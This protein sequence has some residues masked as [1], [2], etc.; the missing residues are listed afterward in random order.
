MTSLVKKLKDQVFRKKSSVE[1]WFFDFYRGIET[2]NIVPREQFV[3]QSE[4]L[5]YANCYHGVWCS[6]LK[7]LIEEAASHGLS[8]K[9]FLDVG[10]GKGKACFYAS[11]YDQFTE[12]EGIEFDPKL[13]EISKQNLKKF[14]GHQEKI[15]FTLGDAAEYKMKDTETFI[16]LFNPFDSFV[17]NK[18]LKNNLETIRNKCVLAYSNH[19]HK[20]VLEV[21]GLKC[22]FENKERKTSL[23]K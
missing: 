18:F 13:L 8:M 11:E 7:T 9:R 22:I 15:T 5:H 16:F 17:L 21:N 14:R 12:V 2:V 20:E 3:T 19:L 10:S 4:N 1:D 6:N 23:W